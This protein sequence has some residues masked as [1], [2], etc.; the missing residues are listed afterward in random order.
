VKLWPFSKKQKTPLSSGFELPPGVVLASPE[1]SH[2]ADLMGMPVVQESGTPFP[3]A[4]AILDSIPSGESMPSGLLPQADGETFTPTSGMTTSPEPFYSPPD[5][6]QSAPS[7]SAEPSPASSEAAPAKMDLDNFFE[8]NSLTMISPSSPPP[9]SAPPSSETSQM[10][11]ILTPPASPQVAMPSSPVPYPTPQAFESFGLPVPGEPSVTEPLLVQESSFDLPSQADSGQFL[12]GLQPELH[13]DNASLFKNELACEALAAPELQAGSQVSSASDPLAAAAVFEFYPCSEPKALPEL[14]PHSLDPASATE[15][16]MA[17]PPQPL[18]EPVTS[19]LEEMDF[20]ASELPMTPAD[21]ASGSLA[22]DFANAVLGMD[23]PGNFAV[24]SGYGLGNAL[25]MESESG[26]DI[27]AEH[28]GAFPQSVVPQESFSLDFTEDLMSSPIAQSNSPDLQAWDALPGESSGLEFLPDP[29]AEPFT[30]ETGVP[31]ESIAFCGE[32]MA[33]DMVST[34]APFDLEGSTGDSELCPPGDMAALFSDTALDEAGAEEPE[35]PDLPPDLESYDLGHYPDPEEEPAC[36][37]L[38][39]LN[40]GP[41]LLAMME[42]PEEQE[43]EARHFYLEP[44]APTDFQTPFSNVL[45][46]AESFTLG[47]AGTFEFSGEFS[48]PEPSMMETLSSE[49]SEKAPEMPFESQT[50]SESPR[51]KQ[52]AQ[53]PQQKLPPQPVAQ[54][55]TGFTVQPREAS[56]QE[57]SLVDAMHNFEH[58]V[59]LSE[60]RFLK[61][62]LD[63]LVARYFAENGGGMG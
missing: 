12:P 10:L 34:D 14:M 60:S 47:E 13:P 7:S 28:S 30:L 29:E 49:P 24:G 2:V 38:D 45:D 6:F 57:R 32:I 15:P 19:L 41:E 40:A 58:Q 25:E 9:A 42:A 43:P 59:I 31:N 50:S 46:D 51:P 1:E 8:Q 35:T 44:D 55:P 22:S 27:L 36:I 39:N 21:M 16:A 3:S 63:D 61:K 54:Q 53:P 5:M 26:F 52:F 20:N 37:D 56:S 17:T 4:P 23:D 33:E 62:S 48:E 11:D 18:E